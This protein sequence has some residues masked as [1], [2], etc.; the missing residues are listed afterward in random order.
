VTEKAKQQLFSQV[1]ITSQNVQLVNVFL[2]RA[3]LGN[4]HRLDAICRGVDVERFVSLADPSNGTVLPEEE[5]RVALLE[6]GYNIAAN[7]T[8]DEKELKEWIE[9]MPDEE[10]SD[11]TVLFADLESFLLPRPETYRENDKIHDLRNFEGSG[12]L[13]FTKHSQVISQLLA[14]RSG[15]G[16]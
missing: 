15:A 13:F 16:V 7:A 9:S 14:L 6:Q 3:I 8:E 2:R 5:T 11:R 10:K 4:D 12:M 1:D